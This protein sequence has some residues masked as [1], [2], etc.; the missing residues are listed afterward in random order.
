MP[1]DLVQFVS[2]RS[3]GDVR[4]ESYAP[5]GD[6]SGFLRGVED[7]HVMT[8]LPG[9]VRGNHYHTRRREILIV[10]YCDRWSFHWDNGEG[11]SLQQREFHG[12]GAV[13]VRI[14][15]DS[16]HAVRNDGAAELYIAALAD[17]C[18][19]PAAPDSVPRK[20]V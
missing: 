6:W 19:D 15:P 9:H 5:D 2:L 16:S 13:L 10:T 12:K 11:T 4:G 18:F 17:G 3:G 1:E 14:S 7:F 8:I 20:V